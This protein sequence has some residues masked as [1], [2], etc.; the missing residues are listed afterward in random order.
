M[1]RRSAPAGLTSLP[2]RE[3]GLKRNL[4]GIQRPEPASL[5]PRERGLK[6][7]AR[8]HEAADM[9]APPAGAWIETPQADLMS[10]FGESL[11]P[12]ERGLK[13]GKHALLRRAALSLPPRERGL[14]HKRSQKP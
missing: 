5:P 13:P 11:P 8:L 7:F 14:K 3:R 6:H 10:G 1:R 12:R 9:V 4:A 2:P